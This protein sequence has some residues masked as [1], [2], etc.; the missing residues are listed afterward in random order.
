MVRTLREIAVTEGAG[1]QGRK[2]ELLAGLLTR[3]TPLEARYLLRLVTRNLRLG[4]G[5]PTILDALAQVHAG[6]KTARPVLER[7]YNICCDLGKV[8]AALV[9]GGLAAVEQ[10]RVEAGEPGAGHAG[11]S[12]LADAGE[13]LARLGGQCAAEYKYDG[14]RVQAHRTA[15]GRI[16]LF[17]RRLEEISGQ[18]PDVVEL[19]AAGLGP[20]EVIL[21]GEVVSYDAA[22][23]ELRPFGEVYAA[24]PQ[25]RHRPGRPRRARGPVLLRAAVRRRPGPDHAALPA[26]AGRA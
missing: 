3:A 17:T 4:I 26:A 25:A 19:L 22:A 5:T 23:Y 20:A 9:S 24:A 16:E 14:I 2:L 18:F 8:A 15:D 21:E 1:S 11:P 12:R 6:G 7:G 13:I 10:L